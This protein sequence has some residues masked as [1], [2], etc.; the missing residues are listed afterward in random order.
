[1]MRK[2]LGW[3]VSCIKTGSFKLDSPRSVDCAKRRFSIPHSD[4]TSRHIQTIA[5]RYPRT[6]FVSI[7]GDKCIPNLPDVRIPMLIVYRKGEIR[8]QVVAWGASRSRTIEGEE[9]SH[10]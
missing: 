8:N 1:M 2:G 5:A 9:L 6:K 10:F 4:I 7:I 3:F